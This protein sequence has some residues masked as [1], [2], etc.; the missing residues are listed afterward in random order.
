MSRVGFGRQEKACVARG[1]RR[2][3]AGEAGAANVPEQRYNFVRIHQTLRCSPAMEAGL[4]RT[5]WSMD[6]LVGLLDRPELQATGTED[7]NWTT[8]GLPP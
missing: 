5:L 2:A 7:S 1:A 6:D 3:A 8:T 4:S